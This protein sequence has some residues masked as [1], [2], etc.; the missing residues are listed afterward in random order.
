[1]WNQE[2]LKKVK[3]KGAEQG[4][5]TYGHRCGEMVLPLSHFRHVKIEQRHGV[6]HH[7]GGKAEADVVSQKIESAK[8]DSEQKGWHSLRPVKV[9]D[10]KCQCANENGNN[11][12]DVMMVNKL[13]QDSLAEN[14]FFDER[15]DN[16]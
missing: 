3:T 14:E 5:Q 8:Q 7:V 16:R 6:I 10:A 1:M 4:S 11:G 15:S 9:N 2:Q 12:T 13:A